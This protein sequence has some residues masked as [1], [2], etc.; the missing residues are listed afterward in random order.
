MLKNKISSWRTGIESGSCGLLGLWVQKK[1]RENQELDSWGVNTDLKCPSKTGMLN[2]DSL[3]EIMPG[4]RDLLLRK[5]AELTW[6]Q[7]Q[8]GTTAS[9]N[10]TPRW[11]RRYELNFTSNWSSASLALGTRSAISL[12]WAKM[13]KPQAASVSLDCGPAVL[14]IGRRQMKNW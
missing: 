7:S 11:V 14:G 1:G 2:M 6:H 13:K 10:F 9:K 3:L 12:M 4:H 5:E 8:P